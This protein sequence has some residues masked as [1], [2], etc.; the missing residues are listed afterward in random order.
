MHKN[1][2]VEYTKYL[3]LIVLSRGLISY[4]TPGYPVL[5]T[6]SPPVPLSERRQTEKWLPGLLP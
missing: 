5:F 3:M 2:L 1:L 6:D 4:S